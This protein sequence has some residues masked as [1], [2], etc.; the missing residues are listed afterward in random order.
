M[1]D[2]PADFDLKMMPDWLK[3]PASK[4]P[5]ADYEGRDDDRRPRGRDDWGGGRGRGDDRR[6]KPGG[7]QRPGGPRGEGGGRRDDRDRPRKDAPGS[8]KPE[9]KRPDRPA[10]RPDDRHGRPGE[11]RRSDERGGPETREHHAA[12]TQPANVTIEF[13]PDE[14][15]SVSIARQVKSTHRAY[16]LF[17]LARMFLAKP[18]R[19]RLKITTKSIEEPLFQVGKDGP[20]W[21][22]RAA[23]ERAAFPISRNKFYIEVTEQRD[24]PKGNFS[25]VARCR[26]NGA[27][28]GPTNYHDYQPALRR[29]YEERFSRRMSFQDF[30]REIEVVNDP[31]LIE[32]WKQQCSSTTVYRLKPAEPAKKPVSS[33]SEEKPA[34]PADEKPAETG[35][36]ELNPVETA[37]PEAP[38]EAVVE[39]PEVEAAAETATAETEP[40]EAAVAEEAPA[41]YEGPVFNSL[42]EVEQHFKEHFLPGLIRTASSCHLSGES[43]RSLSDRGIASAVRLAWEQERGF[44]GQMMHQLRQHFSRAGLHVF[45]HRKRM[46][47]VSLIRPVPME[48]GSLSASVAEILKVIQG[49]QNCNRASLAAAILGADENAVDPA[50][51]SVLA[52]DLRWLIE[53]GSVIE[54]SDGRLELP[55]PP[56]KPE[57]PAA[58]GKPA[59]A[60]VGEATAPQPAPSSE[61]E[62][63]VPIEPSAEPEIPESV[64]TADSVIEAR[65]P[66]AEAEPMVS[67]PEPPEVEAEPEIASTPKSDLQTAEP[68]VEIPVVG[69]RDEIASEPIPEAPV[70][71][72]AAEPDPTSVESP[73]AEP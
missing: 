39:S 50:R 45:K 25:N 42:G 73:A 38:V 11:Q 71:P 53:T 51:K 2:L 70:A 4:N 56:L 41:A 8:R 13:F 32:Q 69:E 7:G 16:S 47:F 10:G 65:S 3:E 15:C 1:P 43:S 31:A 21:L 59:V 36:E 46:Q 19:H 6:G 48:E 30:L 14:G 60:P 33:A 66:N 55:V 58:K 22:D 12:P 24:A 27:L 44:P 63:T 67:E 54:F 23:A 29:L 17:D 49:N 28:L 40:A 5:Y 62:L 72:A 20:V 35:A 57:A 64:E 52:T 18:E 37:N 26:A 68:A 61:P 9:G 34:A